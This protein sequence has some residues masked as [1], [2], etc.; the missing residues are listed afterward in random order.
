MSHVQ[1][2]ENLIISFII[3]EY[4]EVNNINE[5][6]IKVVLDER[7]IAF[8]NKYINR[9]QLNEHVFINFKTGNVIIKESVPLARILKE[10]TINGSVMAMEPN[11][12]NSNFF[13]LWL[14]LFGQKKEKSVLINSHLPVNVKTTLQHFFYT[15]LNTRLIDK[16]DYLQVMPFSNILLFSY[17][18]KGTIEETSELNYLLPDRDRKKI[19]SILLNWEEEH[20]KIY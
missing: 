20:E 15:L 1:P 9:Y 11:K 8:L 6:G 3:Q 14:C 10:W 19:K 13:M 12:L 7:K 5:S 17:Q 18:R 16:G 2:L 4:T